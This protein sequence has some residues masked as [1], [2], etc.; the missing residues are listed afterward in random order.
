MA[1][2]EDAPR[3]VWLLAT[4]LT[5][6]TVRVGDR[7]PHICGITWPASRTETKTVDLRYRERDCAACARARGNVPEGTR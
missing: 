2:G 1:D 7:Y 6:E 5:G 3:G 4:A